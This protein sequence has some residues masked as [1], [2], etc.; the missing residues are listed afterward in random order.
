MRKSKATADNDPTCPEARPQMDLARDSTPDRQHSPPRPALAALKI[1]LTPT[2]LRRAELAAL[3]AASTGGL[4]SVRCLRRWHVLAA[5]QCR[6]CRAA[7]S[8]PAV[9]AAPRTMQSTGPPAA[10][11][12]NEA[13]PRLTPSLRALGARNQ[14]G[15]PVSLLYREMP[16]AELA[17]TRPIADSL[18]GPVSPSGQ[19]AHSTMRLREYYVCLLTAQLWPSAARRRMARSVQPEVDCAH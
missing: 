5:A 17:G 13:P 9:H 8:P 14:A 6:S 12:E 16:T 15:S 19:R 4:A 10:S 1:V 11:A 2:S 3:P 18:C 7:W